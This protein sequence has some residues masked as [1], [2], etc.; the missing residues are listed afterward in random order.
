[1]LITHNNID[2]KVQLASILS[3]SCNIQD[4]TQ[5]QC[6]RTVYWSMLRKWTWHLLPLAYMASRPN[7]QYYYIIN[8]LM[9][10][11]AWMQNECELS[12]EFIACD[13]NRSLRHREDMKETFGITRRK[14]N[15]S[16][17]TFRERPLCQE[18]T[19]KMQWQQLSRSKKIYK[20]LNVGDWPPGSRTNVTGDVEKYWRQSE[21]SGI[22]GRW[23]GSVDDDD[24]DL[25]M[26]SYEDARGGEMGTISNRVLQHMQ[27][28]GQRNMKLDEFRPTWWGV[29]AEYFR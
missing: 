16:T 15:G 29:A 4:L 28:F 23:G 2:I 14:R 19:L 17:I 21:Q 13:P 27:N 25:T 9:P 24:K 26:L 22:F 10:S 3:W 6:Q 20:L 12:M 11:A 8:W 18:S 5:H 1:M 7:D